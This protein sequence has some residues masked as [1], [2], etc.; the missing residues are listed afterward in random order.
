M[1]KIIFFISESGDSPIADFLDELS[2]RQAQKLTWVMQL[3][4]ELEKIPKQYFKKLTNTDDIWE[5]RA[6]LGS[7]I[8]RVLGF[9]DDEHQFIVTNGFK[10]KTEKTPKNEISLAEERKF[11]HFKT[12]GKYK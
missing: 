7:D 1:R 2:S 11:I 4:E 6:Q 5:I 3:V 9:F 10:K 8:F 12:R